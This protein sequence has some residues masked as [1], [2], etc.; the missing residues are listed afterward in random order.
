[1]IRHLFTV[2]AA[3][4]LLL[5]IAAAVLWV[6]SYR[7]SD[8]LKWTWTRHERAL[9][10]SRGIVGCV[11]AWFGN[12]G[13][14][15]ESADFTHQTARP[16]EDFG[17]NRNTFFGRI[18]FAYT[19]SRGENDWLGI[20]AVRGLTVPLWSVLVATSIMPMGWC[21]LARGRRRRE[22]RERHGQ[23]VR[24]AYDLRAT[25]DRCPEWGTVV[26]VIAAAPRGQE[27]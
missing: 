4:S 18:G 25:P 13:S 10:S 2:A 26:A 3:V 14:P 21:G 17:S 9:L 7:V 11:D 5:F 19:N 16:P 1:M 12:P 22:R 23:C 8:M 15:A 6:R 27:P 20:V 24:C